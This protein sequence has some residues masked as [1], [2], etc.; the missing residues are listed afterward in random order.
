MQHIYS[1][2]YTILTHADSDCRA[3][4]FLHMLNYVH[5]LFVVY[6]EQHLRPCSKYYMFP[7]T[8]IRKAFHVCWFALFPARMREISRPRLNAWLKRKRDWNVDT[9]GNHEKKTMG[10]KMMAPIPASYI[11]AIS[12]TESHSPRAFTTLFHATA[13]CHD[14]ENFGEACGTRQVT[15][16]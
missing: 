12:R 1:S 6:T 4:L 10:T 2:G 11:L 5:S 15:S 9:K 16:H 8:C 13:S 3:G 7:H 14:K